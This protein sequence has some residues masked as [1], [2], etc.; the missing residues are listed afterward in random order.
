MATKISPLWG[1]NLL[2]Q[3]SK[4]A[5]SS[6][7]FSVLSVDSVV[8]NF[9]LCKHGETLAII[10]VKEKHITQSRRDI[11]NSTLCPQRALW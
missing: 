3:S 8:K 11:S 10:A 5:G 6:S 7:Y 4:S 9:I 1:V 2:P